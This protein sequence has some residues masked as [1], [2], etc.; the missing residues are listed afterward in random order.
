MSF[1]TTL[2]RRSLRAAEVVALGSL[3]LVVGS[4]APEAQNDEVIAQ[5][6]EALE[7]GDSG[8]LLD[9]A[10]RRVELVIMDQSAQYSR[11]Q[12]VLVL[13]DF[14]RRYPP[15]RVTLSERSVA[16]DGRA[17]MGRYWSANSSGPFSLYLG[18][19]VMA[20]EEWLLDTIRIERTSLQRTGNR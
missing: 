13:R 7:A 8:A 17:A 2:H 18:F 14:F 1:A 12:A 15:D 16:G 3:L 20:E 19:R 11:G 9:L 4:A 10:A 5:A 6:T